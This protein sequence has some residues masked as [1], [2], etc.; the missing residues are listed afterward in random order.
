MD[1]NNLID[2]LK[3]T[4]YDLLTTS[5]SKEYFF[6]KLAEETQALLNTLFISIYIYNDHKNLFQLVCKSSKLEELSFTDVICD[7]NNHIQNSILQKKVI[8]LEKE[9]LIT[10]KLH[11]FDIVTIPLSPSNGPMGLIVFGIQSPNDLIFKT[12]LINSIQVNLNELIHLVYKLDSSVP[13]LDKYKQLYEASQK[14]SVLN[15]TSEVL[16]EINESIKKIYPQFEYILLLSQDFDETK[17]LPVESI[18][19]NDDSLSSKVF[20]SGKLLIDKTNHTTYIYAPLKGCQGVYGVI[21]LLTSKQIKFSE[22]DKYFLEEFANIAGRTFENISLYQY[23]THLVA[24][25]KLVNDLTHQ[26]NSSHDLVEITQLV[27]EKIVQVCKPGEIGFVYK[28]KETTQQF[29]LLEGSTKFFET[30]EGRSFIRD[31]AQE[32]SRKKEA[33]FIGEYNNDEY[34][35]Y[36]SVMAFPM[37]NL[38]DINGVVFVLHPEAYAFSFD[39]FK[40]LQSI[41]R[42]STLA[43]VNTILKDRLE[44][45]ASTDY[46]T[47]LY[48]RNYLDERIVEHMNKGELGTLILFDI[49]NFKKVNDKFGHYIGDEV[50]KQVANIII[51]TIDE[52]DIAARWGGEELAI[53]LPNTELN[54]G[55]QLA[56]NINNQVENFTEPQVTL[57]A[58]VSSWSAM[59][60]DTPKKFF[61]RADKALYEAKSYGKN[62]VVKYSIEDEKNEAVHIKS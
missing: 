49:D 13:R 35:S 1:E 3:I 21:K 39:Q 30:I 38:G 34:Y 16:S 61:V 17:G 26:L 41:I 20:L 40:L 5:K 46:L 8:E 24:D 2:K 58:G 54:A 27:R 62:C 56:R 44:K 14:F 4:Y 7:K 33:I 53:Y 6:V 22:S 18:E 47:Q 11:N 15:N 51:S 25:L 10:N 48:S 28:K 23:S 59:E 32:I 36:H 42:H 29:E 37:E 31:L 60:E 9:D 50:L 45:V 12:N 43:I 19:L 52:R 57:S 55:V